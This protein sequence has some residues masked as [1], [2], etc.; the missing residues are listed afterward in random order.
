MT[1]CQGGRIW[2]GLSMNMCV[3]NA[4]YLKDSYSVYWADNNGK[5]LYFLQLKSLWRTGKFKISFYYLQIDS[6]LTK[7][8]NKLKNKGIS[9]VWKASTFHPEKLEKKKIKRKSNKLRNGVQLEITQLKTQDILEIWSSFPVFYS[10]IFIFLLVTIGKKKKVFSP[11]YVHLLKYIL[12]RRTKS[13]SLWYKTA[14]SK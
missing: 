14:G 6:F 13:K 5:N 8:K 7:K 2:S 12:H 4:I 10:S 3:H 1:E 9:P 11:R